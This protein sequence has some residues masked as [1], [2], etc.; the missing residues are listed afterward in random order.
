M[1]KSIEIFTKNINVMRK[2]NKNNWYY[3]EGHV[4]NQWVQIKGFNTWLQVFKVDYVRQNTLAD[5]SV[6]EFNKTLIDGV[7]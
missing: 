6:K 2:R 7:N 5:I 4:N 1:S 3:F